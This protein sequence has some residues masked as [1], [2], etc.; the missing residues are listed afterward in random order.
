M[1]RFPSFRALAGAVMILAGVSATSEA[2]TSGIPAPMADETAG[3]P[4][5]SAEPL[6]EA[7]AE[8][9][10]PDVFPVSLKVC[11]VMHVFNRPETDEDLVMVNYAP[12]VSAGES[13]KLAT[14]PVAEGCL[15]SGFGMRRTRLH[16]GV[17]YFHPTAVA[18]PS[19]IPLRPFRRIERVCVLVSP[20]LCIYILTDT[21]SCAL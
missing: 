18:I 14:A 13:V 2:V 3:M 21:F 1:N 9:A 7:P 8:L 10:F 11:P 20:L 5:L 6:P 4:D 12:V 19:L 15:S 16:E 17:A